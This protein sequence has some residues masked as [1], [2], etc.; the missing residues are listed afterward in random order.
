MPVLL[1]LRLLQPV[2][3]APHV[4]PGTRPEH[5][6]PGFW[7]S[8]IEDPDAVVLTP[9]EIDESNQRALRL[10]QEPAGIGARFALIDGQS[11]V[12]GTYDMRDPEAMLRLRGDLRVLVSRENPPG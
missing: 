9:A 8:R 11:R 7:I 4:L 10:S 2:L 6:D 3:P 5:R 1:L 12:R